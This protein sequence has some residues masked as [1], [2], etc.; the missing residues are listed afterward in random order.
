MGGCA[1]QVGKATPVLGE[2]L[3]AGA[4]GVR[5]ADEVTVAGKSISLRRSGGK[6]GQR[7]SRESVSW[8]G[9]RR[10]RV[11]ES[12]SIVATAVMAARR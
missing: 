6:L 12:E 10:W 7:L 9:W 3:L 2:M 5:C 1:T 4:R 8:Y 11:F